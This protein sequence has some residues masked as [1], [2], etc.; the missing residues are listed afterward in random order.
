MGDQ[1]D[2]I[3]NQSPRGEQMPIDCAYRFS[4]GKRIWDRDDLPA[5]WAVA[6]WP[7]NDERVRHFPTCGP[8]G[9]TDQEGYPIGMAFLLNPEGE[10]VATWDEGRWWTPEESNAWLTMLAV[11]AAYVMAEGMREASMPRWW[12]RRRKPRGQR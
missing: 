2:W 12:R 5:G 11:P 3:L 10:P 7:R 8:Q 9:V 1:A 4:H 6:I